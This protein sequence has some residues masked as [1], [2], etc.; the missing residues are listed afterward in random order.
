MKTVETENTETA[1][2][3]SRKYT[4]PYRCNKDS[5]H[6]TVPVHVLRPTLIYVPHKSKKPSVWQKKQSGEEDEKWEKIFA[7]MHMI[8]D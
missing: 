1:R 8:E 2:N 6:R 3:K 4:S 5:L 7:A